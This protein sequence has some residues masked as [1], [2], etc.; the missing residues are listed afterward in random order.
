MAKILSTILS[1]IRVVNIF[2]VMTH[3]DKVD[4]DAYELALQKANFIEARCNINI[5]LHHIIKFMKTSVSLHPLVDII[6]TSS[7]WHHEFIETISPFYPPNY[8]H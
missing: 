8:D 7:S 4:Y 2:V 6:E 1:Y 3:C 5:P